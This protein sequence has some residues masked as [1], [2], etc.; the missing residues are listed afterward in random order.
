VLARNVSIRYAEQERNRL[1]KAL[2]GRAGSV[3]L[4][5]GGIRFAGF[6][7]KISAAEHAVRAEREQAFAGKPR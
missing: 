3:A 1:Q 5:S 7:G 4:A 2:I 6:D